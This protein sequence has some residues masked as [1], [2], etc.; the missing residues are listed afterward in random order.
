MESNEQN[1]LTNR[2]I[3]ELHTRNLYNFISQCHPTKF[4]KN[5]KN[6]KIHNRLKCHFTLF[7]LAKVFPGTLK[8]CGPSKRTLERYKCSSVSPRQVRSLEPTLLFMTC[9]SLKIGGG[10]MPS[11][12]A[13]L[14]CVWL[15]PKYSLTSLL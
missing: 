14:S 13:P 12:L 5:L 7:V 10:L 8:C 6:N 2:C 11:L 9:F 15:A 3:I 4:N 1:K